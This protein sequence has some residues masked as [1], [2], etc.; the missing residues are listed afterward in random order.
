M[1][2]GKCDKVIA[3]HWA[4]Y[5]Q[6]PCKTVC[7]FG[8]TNHQ[9]T[10]AD[11]HATLNRQHGAETTVGNGQLTLPQLPLLPSHRNNQPLRSTKHS[12]TMASTRR[13]GLLALVLSLL[14]VVAIAAP[15]DATKHA[16]AE[17]LSLEELDEQ[18][19]VSPPPLSS[20]RG[21]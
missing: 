19:Q 21:R 4:S 5:L 16:L 1:Q 13:L 12:G 15:Q 18:L 11:R 3:R 8:Y 7:Q 14:A 10:P 20:R 6:H 2:K 17:S 9:P